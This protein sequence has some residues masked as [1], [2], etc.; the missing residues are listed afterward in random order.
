MNAPKTCC[1]QRKENYDFYFM[2]AERVLLWDWDGTGGDTL[3]FDLQFVRPLLEECFGT[4]VDTVAI[5]DDWLR[6]NFAVALPEFFTRILTM[7]GMY[8]DANKKA[9]HDAYNRRRL[10][11]NF[12]LC[13][14]FGAVLEAAERRRVPSFVVSNNARFEIDAMLR[15]AGV[16][17]RIER[18]VGYDVFFD[19]EGR[20]QED[21]TKPRGMY[22]PTL[23][24]VSL[25]HPKATRYDIFEDSG[26]GVRAADTARKKWP[27]VE[28]ETVE[29]KIWAVATG[30]ET[31]ELLQQTPA[32]YVLHTLEEFPLES[33]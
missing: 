24:Y 6:A 22:T 9:L 16:R 8:S 7:V 18:I 17:P 10:V 14:G 28:Q 4:G 11:A 31:Y 3:Q 33:L 32:D 5:T 20:L 19:G 27:G 29:V 13:P 26:S 15:N 2:N 21:L 12:P 25:L 23:E 1:R 30:G